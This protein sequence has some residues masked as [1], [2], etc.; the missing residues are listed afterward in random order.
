MRL[1]ST[2]KVG[3]GTGA[4]FNKLTVRTGTGN[5]I[6]FFDTGSAF[7]CGIQVVND[8][9]TAYKN[10]D[11][12]SLKTSFL[13]GNVLIGTTT[14]GG[15]KLAVNG[16][17]SI[18][19]TTNGTYSK[20]NVAGAI[21]FNNNAD[22]NVTDENNFGNAF[23][24]KSTVTGGAGATTIKPSTGPYGGLY[25]VSGNDVPGNFFTDLVLLLGRLTTAPIVI[26]SQNYASPATRTYTNS[27]ENLQ[28]ALSGAAAY[29]IY[30][31]G[32]GANETT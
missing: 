3:I 1:T 30:I 7:G 32:I 25:V 13:S 20:L 17:A 10:L 31:T 22:A 21:H 5:N 4:P 11:I 18:N 8:I 16:A 6:D 23:A 19:T 27:G 26:S 28:L 9:N 2:Q 15:A 12:Y 24:K 29:T 14:D